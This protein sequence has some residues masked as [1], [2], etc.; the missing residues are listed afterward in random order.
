ML[1]LTIRVLLAAGNSGNHAVLQML[2]QS[3]GPA[4]HTES[5]TGERELMVVAIGGLTQEQLVVLAACDTK[6]R[7]SEEVVERCAVKPSPAL[8]EMATMPL[9]PRGMFDSP[10]SRFGGAFYP[11]SALGAAVRDAA[12]AA[13]PT[14]VEDSEEDAAA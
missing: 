1:G 9:V 10:F 5:A 7:L 13:C 2:G 12:P 4:H 3:L 14:V 6:P 8:V 11:L